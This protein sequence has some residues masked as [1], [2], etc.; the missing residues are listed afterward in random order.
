[1]SGILD[2]VFGI[3]TSKPKPKPKLPPA[4]QRQAKAPKK[5]GEKASY[6]DSQAS[7]DKQKRRA[8]A[9]GSDGRSGTILSG[10]IGDGTVKKKKLLGE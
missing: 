6:S 2:D 9:G 4:A 3:E 7:R 10:V 5:P 8:L 1:M